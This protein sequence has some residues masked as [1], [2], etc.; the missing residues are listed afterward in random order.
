MG[1]RGRLCSLI[2]RSDLRLSD[3]SVLSNQI[4]GN[5]VRVRG[6]VR[7]RVGG[8]VGGRVRGRIRTL[9]HTAS[10]ILSC[11]L[12]QMCHKSLMSCLGCY[13]SN[14]FSIGV[15]RFY[16]YYF[17]RLLL[18]TRFLPLLAMVFDQYQTI[19][20][21]NF[22]ECLISIKFVTWCDFNPA[23]LQDICK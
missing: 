4:T 9:S 10:H 21:C 22:G 8:H 5:R 17:F 12:S 19:F 20:K 1:V 3:R 13:F 2:G 7:G 6:H 18:F 14:L 15:R 23:H 16:L 11:D